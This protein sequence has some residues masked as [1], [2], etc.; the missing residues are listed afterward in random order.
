MYQNKYRHIVAEN[1]RIHNIYHKIKRRCYNEKEPRY[2]DYGG[3]GIVMCDEWLNPVDG[4][5][6]FVDWAFANGYRDDLT[7]ER[8]DVNGNYCPENCKWITL[9]E[10]GFNQRRTLWVDYKGEHIQLRKLCSRLGKSYDTVHDRVYKRGWNLE[11]ALSEP[12]QQEDSFLKK[13]KEHGLNPRTVKDRIEKFGWSEERA[14]NTPTIGR[15]A[16]KNTYK[17]S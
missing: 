5:D 14:L 7:I 6:K 12:S 1:K 15:G 4:F 11:R 13:C 8:I 2:K 10:Q 16:N 9:K 3:R 17:N